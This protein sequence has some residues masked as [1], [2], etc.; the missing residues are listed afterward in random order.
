MTRDELRTRHQH[1]SEDELTELEARLARR[2]Q[3][4]E[5]IWESENDVTDPPQGV[6]PDGLTKP[7]RELNRFADENALPVPFPTRRK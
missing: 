4:I 5:K 1:L 2:P 3:P 6:G 7:M